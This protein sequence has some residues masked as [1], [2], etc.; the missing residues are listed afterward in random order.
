MEKSEKIIGITAILALVIIVII[1][2]FTNKSNEPYIT[3]Y[4][5]LYDIAV[6]YLKEEAYN[7]PDA[8][9]DHYKF[10]ITYEGLGITQK[11]NN[12][13]AYMWVLGE[14]FYLKDGKKES[15]SAYSVFYKFTFE[16]NK[17]VNVETPKDGS[18][19]TESVKRRCP[20][21][22]MAEKVLNYNLN[23][24][25]A[26][27]I[28]EYY[29]KVTDT[30]KLEKKDI[31]GEN[32]VLFNISHKNGKCVPVNLTVYDN[33]KYELSKSYIACKSGEICDDMLRYTKKTKGTYN[34][35]VMKIIKNSKNADSMSFINEKMPEY[36]IYTG[37]NEF[38]YMMITDSNNTALTEFLK[39]IHVNLH[40][41]ATP[42]YTQ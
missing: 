23:L 35:D 2:F 25:N 5:K 12:N 17:I 11:G 33:G 4:E 40:T 41:C 7:D 19:Y 9:K 15:G 18:Y 26:E 14:S 30:S 22:K 39:S 32:N 21:K 10:F 28:D 34:Y 24:S 31:L 37:N 6:E 38:V 1:S 36:E 20:D 13:F 27:K 8:N 29:E 3:D 42:E 16:K